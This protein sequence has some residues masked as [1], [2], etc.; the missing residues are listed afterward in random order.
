MHGVANGLLHFLGIADDRLGA[1]LELV[2]QGDR[3][4]K[5]NGLF[6]G[7]AS[8]PLRSLSARLGKFLESGD[9]AAALLPR[10]IEDRGGRPGETGG[11]EEE[12]FVLYQAAWKKKPGRRSSSCDTAR[13]HPL[14]VHSI[15]A[16][17]SP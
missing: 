10:H 13:P 3:D 17:V 1:L 6:K 5:S 8:L 12:D 16:L 14:Q 9:M 11:A 2:D 4:A 15:D 7:H